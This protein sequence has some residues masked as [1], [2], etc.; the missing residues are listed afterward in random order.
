M[1][2]RTTA[3]FW[4]HYHR[5]PKHVRRQAREAYKLFAQDP[6]HPGLHF[7]PIHSTAPI[8]SVRVTLDY[9][10]LGARHQD[11]MVWFWIGPHAEYER[12]IASMR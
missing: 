4:K 6:F 5:L 12:L 2:S 3:H 9:R 11:V 8:Y 7:K 1:T 10:A